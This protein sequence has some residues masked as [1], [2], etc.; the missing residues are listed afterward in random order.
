MQ[1]TED[2]STGYTINEYNNDAI[3]VNNQSYSNSLLISNTELK[4]WKIDLDNISDN[5]IDII[6]TISPE[7]FLLGTGATQKNV[8]I[9]LFSELLNQGIGVEIMSTDAACRTFNILSAENRNVVAGL[10]I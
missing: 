6:K 7:I 3:V 10:I 2:T 4:P 1:L 9:G 8:S 5:D